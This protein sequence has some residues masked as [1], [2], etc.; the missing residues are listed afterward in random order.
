MMA[1]QR[2]QAASHS[3]SPA[4]CRASSRPASRTRK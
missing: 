1:T 3:T 2:H 4:R